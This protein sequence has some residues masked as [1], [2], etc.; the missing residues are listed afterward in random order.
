MHLFK[1][2]SIQNDLLQV[3]NVFIKSYEFQIITDVCVGV[4]SIILLLLPL[5]T[6]RSLKVYLFFD[7]TRIYNV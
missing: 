1:Y 7:L 5:L 3:M 4:S 6:N 2:I